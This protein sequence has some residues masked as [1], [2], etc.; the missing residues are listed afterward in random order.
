VFRWIAF[1]LALRKVVCGFAE[2]PGHFRVGGLGS[3]TATLFL[4]FR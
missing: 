1:H 4:N 2:Y 3:E